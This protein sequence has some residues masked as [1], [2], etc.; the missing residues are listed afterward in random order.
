[1]SVRIFR[2]GGSSRTMRVLLPSRRSGMRS[3]RIAAAE[4]WCEAGTARLWSGSRAA[5]VIASVSMLFSS[6]EPN[7]YNPNAFKSIH[8]QKVGVVTS[9]AAQ[10]DLYN[11]YMQVRLVH[12]R[13][14]PYVERA[15]VITV[16]NLNTAGITA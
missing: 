2:R 7:L 14:V 9:K 15:V 13:I 1:M 8:V 12:K 5:Y 16:G 11:F 3:S 6:S 10:I 4:L